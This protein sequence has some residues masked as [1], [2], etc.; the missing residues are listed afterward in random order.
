MLPCS[1]SPSTYKTAVQISCRIVKRHPK[2]LHKP[3][4]LSRSLSTSA[5]INPFDKSL[6][7]IPS[8]KHEALTLLHKLTSL[9][10][11]IVDFNATSGSTRGDKTVE[12]WNSVVTRVHED[13]SSTAERPA[14]I[15]VWG[16][17]EWSGAEDLVTALVS[18]PL[19]SNRLQSDALTHRWKDSSLESIQISYGSNLT[20]G[21]SSLQIPS[22]YLQ[23]FPV[24]IRIS[25]YRPLPSH[26][27]M[28]Q[29]SLS[30]TLNSLALFEA[31]I[32]VIVCN[33]LTT[34]L[35]D[36]LAAQVPVNAILVLTTSMSQA[37]LD[38]LIRQQSSPARGS[39]PK[40]VKIIA[41]D[42][43]RAVGA[44]QTLQSDPESMTA[45][46]RFQ[47]DFVGSK[48]S[49]LTQTLKEKLACADPASALSSLRK[50]VA[51]AHIQDALCASSVSLHNTRCELNKA[52]VDASNLRGRIEEAQARV[53]RDVFAIRQD[54]TLGNKSSS[55][56]VHEALKQAEKEMRLVIDRLTWW[57]MVWRVDEINSIVG[58][59]IA[60]TWCRGL[61]K[62]L[63]L[64]T[65]RLSALQSDM[66][67]SAFN[68]LHTHPG[69]SS[70]V[71]QNSLLQIKASPS[72]HV[73]PE[74]LIEP[75][76]I[77][78]NQILEYPTM[79]LHVAGQRAVLT[80]AGGVAT[81]VGISWAG[82]LG[83]LLGNGEGL[84][85]LVSMETG[86]AVGVGMLSAIASIRWAVGKWEKSKKR[87]W[88]DWSRVG[89][90]LDRDLKVCNPSYLFVCKSYQFDHRRSCTTQC[91]NEWLWWLKQLA[92]GCRNWFR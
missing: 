9:L 50:K 32:P 73:T 28:R 45:V 78:R 71:L 46:Q 64:H 4:T 23:E 21:S 25:E 38:N 27:R 51:L 57:K 12:F 5:S 48:I 6:N 8:T 88:Q 79:R 75:I 58:A 29:T 65:G 35:S 42:P 55:D 81:G 13:L 31:D 20:A 14:E 30:Q 11:R 52:F 53:E 26:P 36:I 18:D 2:N 87:W 61:E 82:W 47:D 7:D 90:G 41:V 44:I 91:V 85:G 69:I 3:S 60:R 74:S 89:E 70:A 80:M 77:R 16:V 76:S 83:W 19:A 84:L 24:P 40:S 10:P 17:D 68:L 37:D 34:P 22:A 33:P 67:E 54:A 62:K 59:A 49:I 66:S 86:T 39:L 63:I 92:M 72:Y 15:I 1:A 43:K 56:E